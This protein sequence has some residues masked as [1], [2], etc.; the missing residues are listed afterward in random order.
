MKLLKKTTATLLI[1]LFTLSIF[2]VIMPVSAA[3]DI[4]ID[5]VLGEEEW[6]DYYLG[7]SVTTW[8][9]GMSVDVYGYADDTYLYAAYVADKEQPGW[10]VAESL[11]VDCNFY[12]FTVLDT[13]FQMWATGESDQ[14]QQTTDWVTWDDIGTLEIAGVEYYYVSMW[15]P[16]DNQGVVELKI[17]LSLIVIEGATQIEL[18]GQYWQYDWATLFYVDLPV[19]PQ[20]WFKAS[21]GG[22]SYRGTYSRPDSLN[23]HHCTLGVIGMSLEFST[24]I[25]DKVPCKGSGTF[26]DHD[27]KIKISFNIEEGAIVRADNLIYFWGKANVHDIA[28]HEKAYDVPF[29]LGLV[30]DEY[31]GTNRYDVDCYGRYWHGILEPGSEVTVWVWE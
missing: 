29:R 25:G 5:G 2:A 4:S 27:L 1:A 6:D 20:I 15:D 13:L 21:G 22:V 17:P 19:P 3:P 8:Q 28:G 23:H 9:G 7:T 26:I 24:G 14:V 11:C 30:D 18:Y 12:Y 10:A 16:P 31:S